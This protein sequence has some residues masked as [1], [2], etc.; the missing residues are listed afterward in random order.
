MPTPI[1]KP[2]PKSY[3]FGSSI[4]TRS[5]SAGNGFRFGFNGKEKQVEKEGD[6]YDFGARIYDG[7]LG[8]WFSV[9]PLFSNYSELCP[10]NFCANNSLFFV[11]NNGKK[12]IPN[13]NFVGTNYELVY[14]YLLKTVSAFD[15]LLGKF[16]DNSNENYILY[17]ATEDEDKIYN[18][19][20]AVTQNS[21]RTEQITDNEIVKTEMISANS[22]TKFINSRNAD[23]LTLWHLYIVIHEATHTAELFSPSSLDL[24]YSKN[25]NA[26]T[27]MRDKNINVWNLINKN[28]ELNLSNED[29]E[30]L[31]FAGAETSEDFKN[32]I[33]EKANVNGTNL[34]YETN[35]YNERKNELYKMEITLIEKKEVI[36]ENKKSNEE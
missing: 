30:I 34:E 3:S 18:N 15:I 36:P 12:I 4:N 5:F 9:D 16:S 10:Y 13:A 32:Y 25:H 20:G 14:K 28:L 29:I 24:S 19:A 7:R 31:S 23:E 26:Y 1:S 35:T 11:D 27:Q 2:R 33:L 21:I 6:A 8:R 17:L 22:D